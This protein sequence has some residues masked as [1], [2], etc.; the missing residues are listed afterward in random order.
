RRP[1]RAAGGLPVLP[2]AP[3]PRRGPEPHGAAGRRGRLELR[4]ARKAA[5]PAASTA[6]ARAP[7][8][9]PAATTELGTTT[10]PGAARRTRDGPRDAPASVRT[11]AASNGSGPLPTLRIVET[12]I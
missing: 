12:R 6:P 1:P 2:P 5:A 3:P 11:A 8:P 9:A 7:K 4:V 10:E